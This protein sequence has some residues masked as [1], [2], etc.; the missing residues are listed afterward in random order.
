[1]NLALRIFLVY[2]FPTGV[3][4]KPPCRGGLGSRVGPQCPLRV[5]GGE[6]MGIVEIQWRN[7]PSNVS[8]T[9][10]LR[11][12]RDFFLLLLLFWGVGPLSG[13]GPPFQNFWI[14]QWD[15]GY[16][17]FSAY[18]TCGKILWMRPRKTRFCVSSGTWN[19]RQSTNRSWYTRTFLETPL[20]YCSMIS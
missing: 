13:V 11:P 7:L 14:R 5:V 10:D 19:K 17:R 4:Y 20:M 16:K 12:K 9:Q 15:L 8:K 2:V 1:M 6:C 3:I 18:L